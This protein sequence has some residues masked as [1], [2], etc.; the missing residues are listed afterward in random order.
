MVT[1]GKTKVHNLTEYFLGKVAVVG[2]ACLEW[3]E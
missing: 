3:G 1:V 2:V